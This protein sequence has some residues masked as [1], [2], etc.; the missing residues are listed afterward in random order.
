MRAGE[1]REGGEVH[2]D[3]EGCMTWCGVYILVIEICVLYLVA[4]HV[5]TA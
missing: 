4:T 1:V 2:V 3:W 5:H